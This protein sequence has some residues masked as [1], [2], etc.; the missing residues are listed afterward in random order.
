MRLC[1]VPAL[2]AE[3]E[4]FKKELGKWCHIHGELNDNTNLDKDSNLR[5][6]E[7]KTNLINK[8]IK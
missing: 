6:F 2:T 8:Q 4:G 7:R 3:A 1:Q 5:S